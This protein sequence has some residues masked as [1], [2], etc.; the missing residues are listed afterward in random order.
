MVLFIQVKIVHLS[1]FLFFWNASVNH[2]FISFFFIENFQAVFLLYD[3]CNFLCIL[4]SQKCFDYCCSGCCC[5]WPACWP[6]CSCS[7]ACSSYLGGCSRSSYLGG[8]SLGRGSVTTSDSSLARRSV[9]K[10][11]TVQ[12]VGLKK[13][14]LLF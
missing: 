4:A 12:Q 8:R 11:S 7:W 14:N 2:R 6:A 9:A 1:C 3:E 10:S 13:A 5:W